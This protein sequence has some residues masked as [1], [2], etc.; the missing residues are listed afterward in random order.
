M[1]LTAE[2]ARELLHYDPATGIVT[3]KISRGPARAGAEAGRLKAD[4]Y[5]EI[6]VDGRLYT[7]HRVIWLLVKG[8]WPPRQIDHKD[9]VRDHNWFSNL[10]PATNSQN[11]RN[12]RRRGHN[13]SGFKGVDFHRRTGKWRARLVKDGSRTHLGLFVT[14]EGA[15]AAYVA[16]ARVEFGEFVRAA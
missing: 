1:T 3:W 15:H 14:A 12:S 10:R 13:T 16:A 5:R 2:R 8:K 9:T 4:G 7:T 11:Q 6:R